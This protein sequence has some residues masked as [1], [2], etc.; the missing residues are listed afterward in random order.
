MSLS[1]PFW[2]F[3]GDHS[4]DFPPVELA[5][6]EPNGLLAI[7]GDLSPQRILTAYRRGIFPWYSG[8]QPILWWSPNPRTVLFPDKLKISRSL[9]KTLNKGLFEVRFDTAF[10]DV[11]RACASIPRPGQKGTWITPEIH[12]AYCTLHRMGHAHSVESW[13]QGRLAGGLYG[14]RLGQVFYGESMF[15]HCTDASKVAFVALVER[16]RQEGVRIIDCQVASSHL[17]SLGAE[18]I[19]RREFVAWLNQYAVQPIT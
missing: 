8:D 17:F 12:H 5:M 18:E 16:L 1:I 19:P 9:R 4:H 15:S 14:I 6:A 3:P 10:D 2:L 7:G 13:L 11:I